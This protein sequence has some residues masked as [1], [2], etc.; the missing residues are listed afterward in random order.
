[1]SENKNRAR[2]LENL[3]TI[4]ILL[5]CGLAVVLDFLDIPYSADA[6]LKEKI[7]TIVQQGCGA[8]A[9]VLLMI[10]LDI[11]LFG[12]P[13]SWLCLLLGLTVAINNFPWVPYFKGEIDIVRTSGAEISAFLIL[14]LFVGLFEELIFRG[15]IFSVIAGYFSKDKKGLIKTFIVSSVVFGG[16]HI[17]NIAAGAGVGPTVLQAGYS[18]LTGGLFAYLLIKYWFCYC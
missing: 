15:V 8:V 10:R 18:T 2:I 1:M 17:F 11:K 6:Y 5:F 14:C 9:A 12:L 4:A 16:I 13:K 7:S 3:Q